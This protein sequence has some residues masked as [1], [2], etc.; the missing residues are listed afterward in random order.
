MTASR[1]LASTAGE[2]EVAMVL[3]RAVPLLVLD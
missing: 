2:A 3:S 1:H